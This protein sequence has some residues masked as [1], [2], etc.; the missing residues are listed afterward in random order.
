MGGG[1]ARG[2]RNRPDP[3]RRL[4][5]AVE[6]PA[7]GLSGAAAV[8]GG[9][10]SGVE[11]LAAAAEETARSA[12][13]SGGTAAGG[14]VWWRGWRR[15]RGR[16]GDGVD[17]VNLAAS[18]AD[19]AP[20]GLAVATVV[21]TSS[22]RQRRRLLRRAVCAV[23]RR[24]S[25]T[26]TRM[27]PFRSSTGRLRIPPLGPLE[28][29]SPRYRSDEDWRTLRRLV[30]EFGYLSSIISWIYVERRGIRQEKTAFLDA[31]ATLAY[32]VASWN[33][34][35][36]RTYTKIKQG[37]LKNA[38]NFSIG[39]HYPLHQLW[40]TASQLLGDRRSWASRCLLLLHTMHS[41]VAA[42][43]HVSFRVVHFQDLVY[44]SFG[45]IAVW[46]GGQY[47]IHDS[48]WDCGRSQTV[49]G[50]RPSLAK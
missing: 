13:G 41:K 8:S 34:C 21:A 25:T 7:A 44:K 30:S 29:P 48:W 2:W 36:C 38:A 5:L 12:P 20:G 15:R 33:L 47:G 11:A 6:Q 40:D 26:A 39:G 45:E 35:F 24:S 16:Q 50:C 49:K 1:P 37:L 18:A 23:C 9:G 42:T 28:D 22:Q 4:D 43:T 14:G 46:L 27:P 10:G 32:Y 19:P 31:I 3:C 17:E